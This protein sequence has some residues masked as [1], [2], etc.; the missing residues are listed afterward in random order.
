MNTMPK[1]LLTALFS[2]MTAEFADA[3]L[4]CTGDLS[5]HRIALSLGLSLAKTCIA[6]DAQGSKLSVVLSQGSIE[7]DGRVEK[8][9]FRGET[10][11]RSESVIKGKRVRIRVRMK[12]KDR[13]RFEGAMADHHVGGIEIAE[14]ENDGAP[15]RLKH[16][17]EGIHFYSGNPDH[18]MHWGYHSENG[19]DAWGKLNSEWEVCLTGAQQSPVALSLAEAKPDA[20]SPLL[21]DYRPL[22]GS[23]VN[24]G[25]A[26]QVNVP[27]GSSFSINGKT[28][29]LLQFHAHTPS[30]HIVDGRIY[31]ME[32]HLVHQAA[33]KSKAVI[34]VLVDTPPGTPPDQALAAALSEFPTKIN[35][36]KEFSRKVNPARWLPSAGKRG[37]FSYAGSLTTPPCSEGVSWYVLKE[38]IKVSEDQVRLV[39]QLIGGENARQLHGGRL[40][41]L[42]GR[43]IH[44]HA[45]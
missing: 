23:M 37:Y 19:P 10:S 35:D 22:P 14:R 34:G 17:L 27:E 21:I 29:Q 42:E 24:N 39:H 32:I 1:L 16:R 30:E 6:D 28:Y 36:P 8:R 4:I 43:E 44:F 5:N 2:L 31:P 25:H 40:M 13:I 45:N 20:V 38:P 15:F 11:Y 9:D 41:P 33:D 18:E 12:P 26:L 3:K 7:L